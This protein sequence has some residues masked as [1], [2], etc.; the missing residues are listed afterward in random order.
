MNDSTR[1]TYLPSPLGKL[2]L[3]A[4][5]TALTRI[6]FPCHQEEHTLGAGWRRDDEWFE[7]I[8]RQLREY[9]C[10][11]RETFDV[12]LEMTG[13]P[14]ERRVWRELCKIPYGKTASYGE[15]A[16][17][18]GQP[19][20]CRAVGLANGRNPVPIIVPCHRV[21][22]SDGSLTGYGGGLDTKRWLLALERVEIAPAKHTKLS[23][24]AR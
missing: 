1:Y 9:F 14:F 15:I 8:G 4:S 24:A 11:E 7:D 5:G 10:G 18:I 17:R 16:K 22:G 20:A 13:T 23:A 3:T 21:I 19:T 12:K 6:C 2:L